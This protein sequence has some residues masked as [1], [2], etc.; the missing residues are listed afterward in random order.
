M[1]TR[2]LPHSSL[3]SSDES[4][5]RRRAQLQ[6]AQRSTQVTIIGAGPYG[7]SIAAHLRDRGVRYRILGKPMDSWATRMPAGMLLKSE[8]FAS[9][10]FDPEGR[11]TLKRVCAEKAVSYGDFGVPVR[12]ETVVAYG[13]WFQEQLVPELED[14]T[15][16]A[17]D[18]SSQGFVLELD[19]GETVT[20]PRVIVAV[21]SSQFAYIPPR[22]RLLPREFLSHSC[23][24]HDLTRFA[25]RD[26]TIVGAGA[27]ALDIAALSHEAG[28]LVRLIARKPTVTFNPVPKPRS[29]WGRIR[30]PTSM[31]G[32]GWKLL[33]F[34]DAAMLFHYLP[35]RMRVR[36]LRNNLGAAGGWSMKDRVNARI[37]MLLAQT[38]T[39]AEIRDERVHLQVTAANG[40]QTHVVTDHVIAA[41][42]YRVDI[43]RLSFLS[44]TI[45]SSIRTF[46]FAPTLSRNFESSTP[47][48]Y[49]AGLAAANDFGPA[50]RFMA[51]AGYTARCLSR[52][53][54]SVGGL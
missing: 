45:R 40:N 32:D 9:N 30:R 43:R 29:L 31:L 8:G 34:S 47:G 4:A 14:R 49:F 51:G 25:G 28:A 46:E 18:Q 17:L 20:T 27:S 21:G 36:M 52:H 22:L 23:E 44:E 53:L 3:Q 24:H 48:L 6:V 35:Q 12:L 19:N 10:L 15:V 13:R 7:L 50:M 26:L 16:L 1:T 39:G 54:A 11:F 38:V 42:G 41:T 2:S 37:P 33:F 5:I